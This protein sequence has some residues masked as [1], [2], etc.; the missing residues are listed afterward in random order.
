[1]IQR[2]AVGG[3][4][5]V[6]ALIGSTAFCLTLLLV[7]IAGAPAI[8]GLLPALVGAG[9]IAYW[10]AGQAASLHS[11]WGRGCLANGV[12]S[13]AVAVGSGIQD[14]LWAGRSQYMDEIDRAIG[15][16]TNFIWE[17]AARIGL[18]ALILAAI[19]FALSYWLLG[20]PHHKA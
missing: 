20:P 6:G 7:F 14:D 18:V 3:R 11:A 19:L 16:L 9:L 5:A 4:V 17:L 15:P 1:V 8:P 13:A 10:A 2:G 12:L